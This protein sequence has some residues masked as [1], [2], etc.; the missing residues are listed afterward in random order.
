MSNLDV[1][2]YLPLEGPERGLKVQPVLLKAS[3]SLVLSK[4]SSDLLRPYPCF[5]HHCEP[6]LPYPDGRYFE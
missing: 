4:A 3:I 5:H 1:R 2:G 6:V